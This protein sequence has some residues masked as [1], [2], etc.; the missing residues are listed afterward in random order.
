M[1]NLGDYEKIGGFWFHK[2]TGE[3]YVEKR[4]IPAG[5]LPTLSTPLFD[6]L[7]RRHP[8]T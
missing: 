6:M 4:E 1:A 2:E 5:S 8:K 7:K 3:L